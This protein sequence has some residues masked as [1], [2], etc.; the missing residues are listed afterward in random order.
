METLLN[1]VNS[2]IGSGEFDKAM[3]Q[4]IF[5]KWSKMVIITVLP[6]ERGSL[7]TK[8]SLICDHG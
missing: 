3:K 4:T 2:F 8:S 1:Q 6:C 5:E 7:V